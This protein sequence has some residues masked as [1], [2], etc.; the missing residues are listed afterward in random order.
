M[1]EGTKL[2]IEL[3]VKEGSQKYC[4]APPSS[5]LYEQIAETKKLVELYIEA[6]QAGELKEVQMNSDWSMYILL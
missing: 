2:V 3:G 1:T 4:Y 5:K 6:I